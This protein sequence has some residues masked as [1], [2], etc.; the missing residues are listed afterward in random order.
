[1]FISLDGRVVLLN[2]TMNSISILFLSFMNVS[3]GV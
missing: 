3:G 2:S 1:M